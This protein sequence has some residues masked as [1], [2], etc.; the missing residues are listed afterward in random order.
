MHAKY[1]Q[2]QLNDY[3]QQL[4]F[5]QIKA[6]LPKCRQCVGGPADELTCHRCDLTK[7]LNSFTKVQRR[8]PDT[9]VGRHVKQTRVLLTVFSA[10]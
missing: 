1:S 2:K 8:K 6:K 10:V 9:A 4:L 5:D 3:R 7:G